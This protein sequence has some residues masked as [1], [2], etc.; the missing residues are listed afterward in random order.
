MSKPIKNLIVE[1]YR[2][3]FADTTGAVMIDIRGIKSNDNNALRNGLAQKQIRVTIVKNSLARKAW[4]GTPM[5]NLTKLLEGSCA[6]AVGGESVVNVARELIEQAK[7]LKFEF[8]G[9]LMDGQVFA[10]GEIEAL[11]KYPTRAEAQAQVIQVILSPAGQVIGAALSAGGQI[12]GIIKALEEKLE[13]GEELK[14]AG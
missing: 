14:K 7:K 5:E 9:A 3:R 4:Q 1:N 11:S 13:K 10:A 8:K 2:G 12:A 6:I